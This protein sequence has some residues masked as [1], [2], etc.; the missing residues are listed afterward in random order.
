MQ[1]SLLVTNARLYDDAPDRLSD[2]AVLDGRISAVSPAAAPLGSSNGHDGRGTEG[3]EQKQPAPPDVQVIDAAGRTVIPGLIDV[4]VHGAGGADVMDGTTDALVVMARTLACLGTTSFL[5]TAFMLPDSR[6]AQLR[7]AAAHVGPLP[8]GPLPGGAQLLGLHLEGPFVNPLRKGGLPP[9]CLWP[10]T[11]AAIDEVLNVT[12]G[13]LRMITLAPELD[14][15]LDAV[16]R[17]TSAGVIVSIGHTD[18]TCVQAR[19]GIA[20]GIRH[21]THLYNAM[22]PFHHREPGPLVAIHEADGVTV[23]LISDDVHVGRDA[24]RWTHRIFGTA[25]CI[26]TTDGIRTTGL[27]DGR[28]VIHGVEYDSY[29]GAVRYGD[30]R[31]IGTSLPLLHVALRFHEYTGCSFAE[32]IDS[33]SANPARLLGLADRK[34]RIAAGYDADLVV[35]DGEPTAGRVWMSVVAGAVIAPADT[36]GEGTRIGTDA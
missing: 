2:I 26:C 17:F 23:Q 6:N 33:A 28:H 20:A 5:G 16:R 19:A 34:G 25:R 31:L 11:P 12:G 15:G 21:A 35:L 22:A 10:I 7:L 3:D 18:A 30:G 1:A 9:E 24:V 32:A 27:P 4:H 13:A 14:D 36:A 8:V 29:D